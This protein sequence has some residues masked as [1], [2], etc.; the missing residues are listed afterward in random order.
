[1]NHQRRLP[2]RHEID[3]SERLSEIKRRKKQTHLEDKLPD[4]AYN[5]SISQLSIP[6]FIINY[7]ENP[8]RWLN[9]NPEKPVKGKGIT[10]GDMMCIR[11]HDYLEVL[12]YQPAE[13]TDFFILAG[14]VNKNYKMPQRKERYSPSSLDC[15]EGRSERKWLLDKFQGE[16][17]R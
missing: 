15:Y 7:L 10:L 6:T 9:S 3:L 8:S 12:G 4:L 13:I 17:G 16:L 14:R 1:M 2:T 11:M 5:W